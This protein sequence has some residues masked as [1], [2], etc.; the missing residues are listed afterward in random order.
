MKGGKPTYV[1]GILNLADLAG[2]ERTNKT[3]ATG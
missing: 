2:S 3:H 1:T